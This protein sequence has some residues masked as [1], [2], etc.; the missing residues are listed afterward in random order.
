MELILAST[1]AARRALLNATALPYRAVS[2]EVHERA[3]R[4]VTPRTLARLLAIKKAEAV[5]ERFPDALVVGSDQ[6]VDLG[7]KLLRK[8]ESREAAR[9]QLRALA[10]HL[11]QLHTGVAVRRSSDG[12]ART[13]VVSVRLKMRKLGPGEL[14]KYLDTHEWEGCAGGYRIESQGVKILETFEG[15]YHAVMG[16]PML[17]L[18]KMLREAGLPMF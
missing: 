15:D 4:G 17:A 16:L 6:T 2:P 8:P 18:L 11:H 10:G 3:P 1:S 13:A 5:A 9:T 7:G 14:E 12:F